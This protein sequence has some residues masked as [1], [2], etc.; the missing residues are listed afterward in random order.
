MLVLSKWE[1]NFLASSKLSKPSKAVRGHSDE[2]ETDAYLD[3]NDTYR[4]NYLLHKSQI[5]LST[6]FKKDG[7]IKHDSRARIDDVFFNL[8]LIDIFTQI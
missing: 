8:K 2:T 3:R 4:H 6:T 1:C 7:M 5:G